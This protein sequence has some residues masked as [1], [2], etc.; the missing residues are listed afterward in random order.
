MRFNGTEC[1]DVDVMGGGMRKKI[2]HEERMDK[3]QRG[4]SYETYDGHTSRAIKFEDLLVHDYW[5]NSYNPKGPQ[6][7]N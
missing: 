3:D 1:N 6:R 2:E 4:L 5:I 7:K